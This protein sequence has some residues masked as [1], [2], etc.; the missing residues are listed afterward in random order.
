MAKPRQSGR[1]RQWISA[2]L[3]G[4]ARALVSSLGRLYRA[5]LASFIT[6][7]VIGIALALPAGF[8]LV[9]LNVH[10]LAG[11]WEGGARLSVFI[12]KD[13]APDRYQ[14][15]AHEL[16]RDAQVAATTVITPEAAL[17]EFRRTSGLEDALALL[18]ENPLP[19]VILVQPAAGLDPPALEALAGRLRELKEAELVQLDR[20]WVQ[21]LKAL[22]DLLRRGIWV[23]AA[24]LAMTVIL[25]VGNTIRLE[26]QARRDEIV[27]TKLIGGTDAFIRRPFLYEGIW[28][29]ILG[30]TLAGILVELGRAL[31][32]GPA[33]EMALLYGSGF[34]VKGM[35]I[36][37]LAT[38][39]GAGA[40]LGLLGSWL[41][42][43]RHLAA[44]EP[45]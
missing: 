2:L 28:Y 36:S 44:I 1:L 37:G 13:V 25:V 6:A 32:S 15:L 8:L 31:L 12:H 11:H 20:T 35:G 4:H 43:G 19:P 27:I 9:L 17:E 10:E 45:K 16:R 33:R 26:I 41:A 42:V 34:V 21:R 40:G 30:G 24:L 3:G 38:V 39:L 22:L 14:Q 23:V 29:G 5:P 7:G 18:E